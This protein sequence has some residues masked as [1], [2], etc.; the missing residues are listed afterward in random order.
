VGFT[1]KVRPRETTGTQWRGCCGYGK[2]K[3]YPTRNRTPIPGLSS[4]YFV[5]L[6]TC[7][8]N[9]S[10]T[11]CF[12]GL[13]LTVSVRYC[14]RS[15]FCFPRWTTRV[16]CSLRHPHR[17]MSHDAV[18]LQ[19][20]VRLKHVLHEA[21]STEVGPFRACKYRKLAHFQTSASGSTTAS[22]V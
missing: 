11:K 21:N 13:C 6:R 10:K 18:G 5:A 17:Q 2:I 19:G 22:V 14:I 20:A 15:S 9:K 4:P 3:I 8:I 12:E 16:Y 1:V 7:F